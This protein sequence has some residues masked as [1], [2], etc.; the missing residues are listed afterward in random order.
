MGPLPIGGWD[1]GW[2]ISDLIF[3]GITRKNFFISSRATISIQCSC[4]FFFGFLLLLIGF[5]SSFYNI[6][7]I[8][9]FAMVKLD[10]CKEGFIYIEALKG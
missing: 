5:C 8:Y 9:L 4:F 2:G 6:I 3:N 10:T 7:Y 1:L